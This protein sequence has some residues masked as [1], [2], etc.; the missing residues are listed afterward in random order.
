V[1]GGHVSRGRV[2]ELGYEIR[3][4]DEI[5]IASVAPRRSLSAL[6]VGKPRDFGEQVAEL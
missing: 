2:A 3:P 6:G 1:I 4:D 5:K